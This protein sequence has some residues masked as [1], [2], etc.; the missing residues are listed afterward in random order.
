MKILAIFLALVTPAFA[1]GDDDDNLIRKGHT[2]VRFEF[3]SVSYGQ[4]IS[5]TA[6]LADEGESHIQSRTLTL[7]ENPQ[8]VQLSVP[9]SS[10][11]DRIQCEL[12]V[13]AKKIVIPLNDQR[14]HRYTIRVSYN[15]S[16]GGWNA[17]TV[18]HRPS[19]ATYLRAR[20]SKWMNSIRNR[21]TGT[22]YIKF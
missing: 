13:P 2:Q 14:V 11:A 5:M 21:M 3:P 18:A 12:D 7:G 6:K 20:A 4:N 22:K 1:Q 15:T 8:A 9:F 16:E 17:Q 10:L 19:F